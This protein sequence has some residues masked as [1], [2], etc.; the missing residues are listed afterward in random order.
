[1][2]NLYFTTSH[3]TIRGQK[4]PASYHPD[5]SICRRVNIS[6]EAYRA[7]GTANIILKTKHPE[8]S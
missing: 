3:E 8:H 4:P 6:K 2:I 1:M 5:K 7:F